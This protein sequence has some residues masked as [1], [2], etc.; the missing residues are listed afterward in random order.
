MSGYVDSWESKGLLLWVSSLANETNH[1]GSSIRIQLSLWEQKYWQTVQGG[2][3]RNSRKSLLSAGHPALSPEATCSCP[4]LILV[5]VGCSY[6]CDFK[7]ARKM[8]VFPLLSFQVNRGEENKEQVTP[9]FKIFYF[10][11]ILYLQKKLQN[12]TEFPCTLLVSK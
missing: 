11:L 9:L 12:S 2:P 8:C 3:S 6:L 5:G 10:E 4:V 1:P 7:G